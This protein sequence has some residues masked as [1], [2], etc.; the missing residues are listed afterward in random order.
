ML[1][2]ACHT[3]AA[4]PHVWGWGGGGRGGEGLEEG[5]QGRGRGSSLNKH[6]CQVKVRQWTTLARGHE[7]DTLCDGHMQHETL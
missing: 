1:E 6:S 7:Y 3:A 4:G 5:L 2:M